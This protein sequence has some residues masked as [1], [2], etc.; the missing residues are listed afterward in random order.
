[1][2]DKILEIAHRE[3]GVTE[4]AS[5]PNRIKYNDWFYLTPAE[6]KAGKHADGNDKPWC[7]V[8][9]SWIF[10]MAGVELPSI[11]YSKGYAG[12]PYAIS[13][14]S[15]WAKQVTVPMPGD[16]VFYDWDGDGKFDH[17]GIFEKDLGKGLFQA[18]EGNTAFKNDSNGG[19]VMCRADRRYKNAIFVRPYVLDL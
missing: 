2:R 1:M 19:S 15:R 17:T 4:D 14:M 5:H 12:C 9:C 13:H 16:I 3:I 18:I 8:F 6:I 7:G 10:F 11:D